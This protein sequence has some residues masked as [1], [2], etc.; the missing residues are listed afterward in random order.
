MEEI[1]KLYGL[2]Q[3]YYK[4]IMLGLLFFMFLFLSIGPTFEDEGNGWNFLFAG[5]GE[6]FLRFLTAVMLFTPLLA[7]FFLLVKIE[8]FNF[9]MPM[10]LCL[11]GFVASFLFAVVKD[12]DDEMGW[13]I[14][15]YIV[16][17]ALASFVSVIQVL[18][19]KPAEPSRPGLPQY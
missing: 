19:E 1:K 2:I 16:L 10:A 9:P 17:S 15:L 11:L 6:G 8:N 4:L 12:S 5:Y 13:A 3:P 18:C 7:I 14:I